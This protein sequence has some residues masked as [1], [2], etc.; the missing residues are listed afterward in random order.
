MADM[1][2]VVVVDMMTAQAAA[3]MVVVMAV[4][5]RE[6]LVVAIRWIIVCEW[7]YCFGC[8]NQYR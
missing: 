3:V 4:P 5:V 8:C 7:Y 6:A 2:A 1:A